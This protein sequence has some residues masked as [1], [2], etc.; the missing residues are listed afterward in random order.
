[1]S[2]QLCE[3]KITDTC[4]MT[5]GNEDAVD[6]RLAEVRAKLLA[7]FAAKAGEGSGRVYTITVS[8]TK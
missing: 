4:R 3:L 7:D 2:E 8:S 5:H 1:M 6:K